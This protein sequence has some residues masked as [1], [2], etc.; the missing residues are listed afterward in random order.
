M[1]LVAKRRK[2]V[3]LLPRPV[4]MVTGAWGRGPYDGC[5]YQWWGTV[6][7]VRPSAHVMTLYRECVDRSGMNRIFHVAHYTHV[8]EAV[9]SLFKWLEVIKQN[10][11][12]VDEGD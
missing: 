4:C 5:L 6:E 10:I 11:E 9:E 2:S 8:H 3:L 7:T 12:I 1:G